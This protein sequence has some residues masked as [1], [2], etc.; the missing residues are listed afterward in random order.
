LYHLALLRT[1]TDVNSL[2]LS[3]QFQSEQTKRHFLKT[4][5]GV[6]RFSL[7]MRAIASLP[8]L[9]PPPEE[10]AAIARI[11]DAV[12]TAIERARDA[13]R[14]AKNLKRSMIQQFFYRDLGA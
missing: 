7:G 4:A 8:V 12:D 11:L 2:F 9:L 14:E 5:L 6:T 13:N 1:K 3:F 10:Q